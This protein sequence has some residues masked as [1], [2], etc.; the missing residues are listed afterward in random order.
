MNGPSFSQS[1]VPVSVEPVDKDKDANENVE[2]DQTRTERPV[3]GQPTGLFTQLEEIDI[4]F[5]VFGLP[6]AVVKEAE[7]LR[8]QEIVK[9]TESHPHREALHAD[10]QQNNLYNPFSKN[11]KAM[12]RELANVELFELCETIPK[13]QCSHCLLY[14]NQGIVYCTCA[15][16]LIY[17][18][19]RRKFTKLRLDALFIPNHVKND[20]LMV[21]DMARR[22]YKVSTTWL[23][24]RGRDAARKSTLKVNILQVFTIDFSEIQFIVNHNSQSDGQNKSAKSGMNLHKKTC[25]SSHSRRKE[26]IP[27]TMVSYLEQS[28]QKWAYETSNRFSSRCLD[29]NCQNHESGEQVEEPIHPDCKYHT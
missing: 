12:I 29:E 5:R 1:C 22:K 14:W 28:R 26:K 10:L 20:L 3:S 2:A 4:D 11:S 13:V 6:H 21:L 8:V 23:G 17:S 27:R 25:M 9:R 24:L 7:H 19:C 16:C 15:Q 18:E